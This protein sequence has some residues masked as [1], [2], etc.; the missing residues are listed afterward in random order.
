MIKTKIFKYLYLHSS[1]EKYGLNKLIHFFVLEPFFFNFLCS[2]KPF[3][4]TILVVCN[5]LTQPHT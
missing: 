5:A 3:S 2:L 4:F 1:V